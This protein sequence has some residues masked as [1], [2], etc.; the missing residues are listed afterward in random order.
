ML[1][2]L[3]NTILHY[4]VDN[5]LTALD[6]RRIKTINLLNLI[7]LFFLFTGVSNYFFIGK[8]YPVEVILLF[9]CFCFVS[10]YLSK[11]KQTAWSFTLFT[12]NVN[13]AI[14]FINQYYPQEAGAYLY[15]YTLII[16]VVLLN[17]PTSVDKFAIMHFCI[18]ALFFIANLTLDFP[19][20]ELKTLDAFQL[21]VIWYYNVIISSVVTAVLSVML[22]RLIT[23]QNR[24]IVLQNKDLIKTKQAVDASLKEKEVLLAELHHRVK[25]NL[26]IITG[27]LN[28]QEGSTN[29]EEARQVLG[30]SK[31]RI[32]SMALVHKMLFENAEL[33]NIDV[34]KYTSELIAELLN[35]YNLHKKVK[36]T[37]DVDY[38]ILPVNKSI[39]LGLIL[40]EIVTNSIKYVF[41]TNAIQ[42]QVSEFFVSI[43]MTNGRVNITV[44]DNGPGF[45]QD[46]NTGS[47]NPSLG[48]YLIKTLAEQIDAELHFSNDNGAR[49]SLSFN[50]Q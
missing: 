32:M 13:A 24:E 42:K 33:K 3:F 28:L 6:R 20:F 7:I 36:V 47:D 9:I 2:K 49:I 38:I 8:D 40:N 23:N 31:A 27:L 26:A 19:A 50:S 11:I 1:K 35:S 30:D 16:S 12:L 21:N 17:N 4:G 41:H 45:P 46:F 15:Y 37:Y 5:S 29:S 34:G 44:K 22:T 14:F 48:I 43:K 18:C 39:P 25:N 10:L